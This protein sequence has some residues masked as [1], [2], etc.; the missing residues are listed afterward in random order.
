VH[1]TIEQ[2]PPFTLLD[3]APDAIVVVDLDGSI[4][5]ANHHAL[6]LFDYS[7][8]EILTEQVEV[9]VP[10]PFQETHVTHRKTY[11]GD[12][13]PRSFAEG[14]TLAAV[15]KDGTV[16]PAD[17]SLAPIKFNGSQMTIAVIRD[18]TTRKKIEDELAAANKALSTFNYSIAHDLMAPIRIMSGMA[19]LLKR[20]YSV[21]LTGD[22]KKYLQLIV[23]E[24]QEAERLTQG[25]LSLSKINQED[26]TPEPVDL[27]T[28]ARTITCE[29]A[30]LDPGRDVIIEIQEGLEAHLDPRLARSLL[31]NL[32]SNAWKFT[33]KS[34]YPKI[35]V[36]RTN[37]EFFVQ[38]NGVG[39]DPAQTQRLFIPFE[40]LH[41]D[42]F[43]GN[44]L[45]LAICYRIVRCHGGDLRAENHPD[46][47]AVFFFSLPDPDEPQGGF[48]DTPDVI[49][50]D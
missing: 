42:A 28:L 32:L 31:Q 40:R 13:R 44:G 46:G 39:F 12:P 35:E 7:E 48:L 43:T 30:L 20:R 9:L 47:G 24:A 27:S 19:T 5:Y 49:E 18:V 17:I 22:A 34:P 3:A 15:K 2:L 23:D 38:D 10:A 1:P 45:G 16:F 8:G 25:L 50:S 14:R 11:N 41:G 6:A 36:G 29:L 4:I 26:V 37:G 21:T 33:G